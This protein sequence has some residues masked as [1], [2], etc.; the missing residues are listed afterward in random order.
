MLAVLGQAGIPSS[1][2]APGGPR[3]AC[4]RTR[5][6]ASPPGSAA[7]R[8]GS[9]VH[10]GRHRGGCAGGPRSRPRPAADRQRH[11]ARRGP[12]RGEWPLP[13]LPVDRR[14]VADLAQLARAA[15][16]RAARPGLPD[17][18]QQRDGRDP[19]GGR[20]RPDLPR[21]T[22]RC[23]TSTRCRRRAGLRCNLAALG[24]HSLALSSHKL[25]GPPGAG[26]LLLAPEVSALAPLIAGGGQ[27]RGRRGG[28]P[29]LPAIAGFA[30]AARACAR[31][32][33]ARP[34]AGRGRAGRVRGT[35]PSCA[36]ATR[37]ACPTRRASPC[38]ACG[39]T[40]R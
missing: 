19:A 21:R 3:A 5:G 15:G 10:L 17:A 30:A 9:G 12:Q 31:G 1:V 13:T 34:L 28:T 22:A 16:G 7:R 35:A 6:R 20:G 36:A 4:S 18:R 37:S 23:C 33:R 32:G 27:E 24:A 39:P 11:R 14:G 25:G 38:P 29:A 40:R 8:G 2:H 26:A